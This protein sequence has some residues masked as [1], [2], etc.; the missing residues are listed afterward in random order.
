MSEYEILIL[1]ADGNP[2]AQVDAFDRLE[3]TLRFN[4]V[5]TWQLDGTVEG[6]TGLGWDESLSIWRDGV[7]IL[8]GQADEFER[9]WDFERYGQ[10][11]K[12]VDEVIH[13]ADK[14]VLPVPSG[15]PYTS[16][17][18]DARSGA[19]ET[20]MKAYVNYHCGPSAKTERQELTIETDAGLGGSVA[21]DGRFDNLLEFLQAIAIKGGGLGFRVVGKEFQVYQPSDKTGSIVFSTEMGNLKRYR[22]RVKR[23]RANYVI[24]GGGGE[25]TARTFAEKGDSASILRFG[26]REMFRDRRDST[27]SAELLKTIDEELERY[28][29]VFALELEPVH[30]LN[31]MPYDDYW[32]GDQVTAI[33]D[34]ETITGVVREIRITLDETGE[35]ITPVIA[36]PGL[37]AGV[38]AGLLDDI[39]QV[40]SRVLNL[41]RR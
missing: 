12:G 31:M 25:G 32:L 29:E 41:E 2:V 20:V 38:L 17:S 30:L 28:A 11:G 34:G 8:T 23:A 1:N 24:C 10:W 14:L 33:I 37:K 36:T 18:H 26:R 22:Y 40:S 27:D 6:F 35:T 9:E 13:L 15:P 7:E 19:C 16:A 3:L 5:S 39:K 4:D 21:E